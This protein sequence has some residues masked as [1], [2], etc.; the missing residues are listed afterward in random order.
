MKTAQ[1]LLA[2]ALLLSAVDAQ[3]FKGKS[4]E[5]S[6]GGANM[7]PIEGNDWKD[8]SRAGVGLG[9]SV[10]GL[11]YFYSVL[12]IFIDIDKRGK[13]YDSD[14]EE[15]LKKI[16]ELGLGSRM[17]EFKAELDVRLSGSKVDSGADDQLIGEAIKLTESQYSKYM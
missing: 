2:T 12:Q 7:S 13:S 5:I 3:A 15:D 10:F 6:F 11:A 14:I 17:S 8:S 1:I 9:F 4:P 16:N